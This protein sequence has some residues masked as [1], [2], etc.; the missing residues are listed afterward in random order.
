MKCM[1]QYHLKCILYTPDDISLHTSL[2]D[3]F[4]SINTETTDYLKNYHHPKVIQQSSL[5][6]KLLNNNHQSTPPTPI[7]ATKSQHLKH[8]LEDKVDFRFGPIVMQAIDGKK[9]EKTIPL[10]Y[11]VLHLYRD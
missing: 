8:C 1:F 7:D 11:G 9:A 5:P 2:F 4:P 3:D 6:K 10:G